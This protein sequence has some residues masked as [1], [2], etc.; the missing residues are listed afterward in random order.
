MSGKNIIFNDKNINKSK[1]YKNE[2]PFSIDDIHVNKILVSKKESYGKKASFKYFI[3][4]S[5]N[6]DIRPLCIRL[7]QMIGSA[8]CSDSNKTMSEKNC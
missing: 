4:Y 2:K 1:F 7:P 8:K 3:G 5:Y 6:D